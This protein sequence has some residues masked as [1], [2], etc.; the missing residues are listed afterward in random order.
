MK[1]SWQLQSRVQVSFNKKVVFLRSRDLCMSVHVC[2]FG[3]CMNPVHDS[4]HGSVHVLVH[5][6]ARCHGPFGPTKDHYR[7]SVARALESLD[8]FRRP[9]SNQL[10]MST[11]SPLSARYI[12]SSWLFK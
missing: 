11:C 12:Y 10:L 3:R 1:A 4:V 7:N 2:I 6:L 9:Q 8:A 5:F